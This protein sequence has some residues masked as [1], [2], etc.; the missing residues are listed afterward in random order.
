[1]TAAAVVSRMLISVFVVDVYVKV[2]FRLLARLWRRVC[3]ESTAP[4]RSLGW[5]RMPQIIGVGGFN[6][7]LDS[8]RPA[9]DGAQATLDFPYLGEWREA[10]YAKIVQKV[11]DRRYWEHWAKDV[12]VVGCDQRVAEL[13]N[14]VMSGL[15]G[16]RSRSLGVSDGLCNKILLSEEYT[17]DHD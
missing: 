2:R 13:G 16:P 1:M 5:R 11:G 3:A 12:S 10:I 4:E 17:D 6:D 7:G 8:A 15:G 14:R 9:P